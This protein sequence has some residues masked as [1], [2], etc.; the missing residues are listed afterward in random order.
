MKNLNISLIQFNIY[1][2]NPEK[3]INYLS[4]I[5]N[6]INYYTDII[7]FPEMFATGFTMNARR[8]AGEHGRTIEFMK[9]YSRKLK[10]HICGSIIIKE[11]NKYFNRLI[12]ST[13]EG[14]IRIYDKR[15]LFRIA[16][17]H[18]V[19]SAGNK[20]LT[21][22]IKN[23]KIKFFICYD[24][25]FPVWCRNA[26]SYDICIFV[27]NWPSKR[28][29]HW[30]ELLIARAIEN[31]SYAVGVNRTGKD[32]NGIVYPGNS[33]VV[34]PAGEIVLDANERSGV[35]NISLD[36]KS[37]IKYRKSLPFYKDADKFKLIR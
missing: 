3:N 37:L 21:V 30:K 5:L 31:Q 9:E 22:K 15:H 20:F 25:R 32:G 13:P 35:F 19:Y 24:L 27:A 14:K 16:N 10:T 2:E 34:S 1:W 17:E 6:K 28:I 29:R 12:L 4:S 23:W 7:I 33:T 8:F 26:D 11:N 18:K 36:K